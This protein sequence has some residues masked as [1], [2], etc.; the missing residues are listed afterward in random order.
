MQPGL[1]GGRGAVPSRHGHKGGGR[2]GDGCG[3]DGRE[4]LRQR[5]DDGGGVGFCHAE[6]LR[7]GAEG[8]GRGIAEG[9]QRRQ[10]GGQEDVDPLLGF[11]LAPAKQA[12]LHHLE[13]RGLEGGEQEEPPICRRRQGAVFVHGKLAGRPGFAIEAPRGH[14]RL[15][16]RLKG[17]NKL[18][19]LV[20]R[21]A[22]EIQ[23]RR[24]AGLQVSKP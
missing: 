12:S 10:Q 11:T 1:G 8:A 9:A 14:M 17:W 24:G 18:R 13:R 21:Q 2:R 3:D 16:R 7:Q 23:K 22:R 5:A 4:F 15:E 19:K 20:E 6:P